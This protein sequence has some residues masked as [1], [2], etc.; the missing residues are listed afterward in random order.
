MGYVIINTTLCQLYTTFIVI[1]T[2]AVF[3]I[4][5]RIR[6]LLPD[7]FRLFAFLLTA[8][9][10]NANASA[11]GHE[12]EHGPHNSRNSQVHDGLNC[13][14]VEQRPHLFRRYVVFNRLDLFTLC[15]IPSS[16]NP[17]PA[18]GSLKAFSGVLSSHRYHRRNRRGS[19]PE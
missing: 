15:H 5:H 7:F 19:R 6:P 18:Q 9:P 4:E 3:C 13:G 14:T 1:D 16:H 12:A 11:D 10:G 2:S 8:F 17:Y